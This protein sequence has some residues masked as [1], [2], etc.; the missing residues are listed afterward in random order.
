MA[1]S[2]LICTQF[3]SVA[4]QLLSLARS[5]S[6]HIPYVYLIRSPCRSEPMASA[7][8]Q[9]PQLPPVLIS[10]NTVHIPASGPCLSSKTKN[11]KDRGV[12]PLTD[13]H[14]QQSA[15][16]VDN[17]LES[18]RSPNLESKSIAASRISAHH[19]TLTRPTY[20]LLSNPPATSFATSFVS[21]SLSFSFSAPSS[22][23][24]AVRIPS[25]LSIA[26]RWLR[27]WLSSSLIIF[28]CPLAEGTD[29]GR[30][31]DIFA[32]SKARSSP[33]DFRS[34]NSYHYSFY[35][36]MSYLSTCR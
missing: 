17:R 25:V 19:T 24:L 14:L 2:T 11:K 34:N 12:S 29:A 32:A 20:E 28:S 18:H 21:R 9:F 27:L 6:L 7:D 23:S 3:K 16:R 31:Q 22:L 5:S 15:V 4:R 26:L 13:Y 1:Q 35:K 10:L 30:L 8:G 36:L 33:V